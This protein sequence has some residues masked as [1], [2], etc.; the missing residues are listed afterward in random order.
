MSDEVIQRLHD[1]SMIGST[2]KS[3]GTQ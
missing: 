2:K 1:Q 3:D